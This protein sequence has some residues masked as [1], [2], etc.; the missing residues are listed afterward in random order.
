MSLLHIRPRAKNGNAA[1]DHR[2]NADAAGAAA[3]TNPAN[4]AQPGNAINPVSTVQRPATSAAIIETHGIKRI[5]ETGETFTHVLKGVS[6]SV[7]KGEFLAIMGPSGSGKSTLMNTL[8]LLDRPSSGSYRLCGMDV[9]DLSDDERSDLRGRLIGFVF[10]SFNLLPRTSVLRNVMLPLAYSDCPVRQREARAI[11]ALR[12][13]ALSPMLFDRKT[14]ELSGGQMQRVAIARAL[15]RNPPLILGDEPTGN[16]D[17]KTGEAV[18]RTFERLRDAGKTIVLIT[19]SP[20]VA[21]RADRCL[22]MRDGVL[23]EGIYR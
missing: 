4:A 11:E 2:I 3:F 6:L 22:H 20:E 19:H 16:L 8:G 21:A 5:F 10:Q 12:S 13:V 18:M 17:S 14:N 9:H 23:R 15:V 7:R 1:V